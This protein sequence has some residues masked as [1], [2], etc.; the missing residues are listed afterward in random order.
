MGLHLTAASMQVRGTLPWP[1]GMDMATLDWDA[2]F[3]EW[4]FYSDR[5]W[6]LLSRNQRV[7]LWKNISL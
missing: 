6:P 7:L 3:F 2:T 4:W 1:N 5:G